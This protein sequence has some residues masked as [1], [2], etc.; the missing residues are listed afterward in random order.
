M[1]R[2]AVN[3]YL[4]S[5]EYVPDGE[6]YVFGDRVYIYGSHDRFDGDD[7][8]LNE[9]VCWSASV[10]ALGN[11]KYEGIIYRKEQDPKCNDLKERRL[12]APD[13][14]QGPDGR[15]YLYYSFDFTGTIGVAVCNEPAGNFEYYGHV[16]YNDGT[17]LGEAFD[18]FFQ[19]DPGV[20]VDDNES[21]Y[22]Y[23]G[24]CLT[25]AVKKRFNLPKP[26]SEGAMVTELEADMITVKVG[27][28]ICL[29][30]RQHAVGT[31]FEGHG[32]FEAASLRKIDEEYYFIYSSEMGHELCY[33]RSKSPI[34]HYTY[35]GTLISNGDIGYMGRTE[36]LNYTGTNHGSIVQIKDDW[37]VFY[38]RQ[39][40]GNPYSRQGCAEKIHLEKD[41]S[42]RQ[43]EMTSCGLNGDRLVGKGTYNTGIACCIMSKNGAGPYFPKQQITKDHPYITQDGVDVEDS[44]IKALTDQSTDIN[45]MEMPKQ[46]VTQ[47]SDGA[48]VGFKYFDIKA[49]ETITVKTRGDGQGVIHVHRSL[50]EEAFLSIPIEPSTVWKAYVGTKRLEA[51]IIPLWFRYVGNKTIDFESFTLA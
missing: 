37:Y 50:D 12:F 21:V 34:S 6:P 25:E 41:G 14:A 10:E 7:F 3:P 31:D 1:N 30:D 17:L 11:W 13:V 51:G 24:F 36:P 44:V 22:L 38:H 9:Y 43:V 29:P 5:Y 40:N 48:V 32:F 47:M 2:Q 26:I 33:A 20:L 39:T 27:P 15:Y 35:G 19:Y 23:T 18:D 28:K 49:V 42:I 45:N 8:C 16:A 4:P 46:Y